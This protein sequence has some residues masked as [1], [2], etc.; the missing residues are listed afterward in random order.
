MF[1]DVLERVS[2]IVADLK[3]LQKSFRELSDRDDLFKFT[4]N[5]WSSYSLH[6]GQVVVH[7]YT[8][9]ISRFEQTRN[10]FWSPK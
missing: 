7:F 2:T 1:S 5:K 3:E 6:L 8:W 9:L 4:V 10:S